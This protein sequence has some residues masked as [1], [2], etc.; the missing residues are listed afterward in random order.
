MKNSFV[1]EVSFNYLHSLNIFSLTHTVSVPSAPLLLSPEVKD[2]SI[3]LS[4]KDEQEGKSPIEYYNLNTT[5]FNKTLNSSKKMYEDTDL[6]PETEYR[7]SLQACN[8]YGCSKETA[9]N[10]TTLKQGIFLCLF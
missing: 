9:T 6:Q 8:N 5:S 7:Y 4:W 3:I 1:T 10:A 2:R